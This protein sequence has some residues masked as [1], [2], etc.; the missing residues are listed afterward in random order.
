MMDI[1][2][3]SVSII[4]NSIFNSRTYVLE[5]SDTSPVWLVDCG[6]LDKVL[7]QIGKRQIL[8]LLLTHAHFDHIYGIP[9]LLK[10]FPDCTIITNAIG[11]ITLQSDKLNMSRY[12]GTPISVNP[13]NVFLVHEGD[14]VPLYKGIDAL[15]YDTPGH[16]P[17][18][19]TFEI[20]DFLFTGDAYIP[21]EKVITNLPG[22]NKA[23]ATTSVDRILSLRQG[24]I[25][26]PGHGEHIIHEN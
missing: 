15:V 22:G 4:P 2:Y 9:N 1:T 23:L 24:K 11:L 20:G 14:H 19:L 18:C 25:I 5:V 26:C 3:P 13:Q 16:H 10:L 6:D 12:H 8:G 21:G 17:S 7:K